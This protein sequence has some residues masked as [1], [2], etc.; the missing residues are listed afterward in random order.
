MLFKTLWIFFGIVLLS[1]LLGGINQASMSKLGRYA[2]L[3]LIIPTIALFLRAKPSE[4]WLWYGMAAGAVSSGLYA[5]YES[6]QMGIFSGNLY[7][8]HGMTGPMEFGHLAMVMGFI[9]VVGWSFFAKQQRWQIVIPLI[10]LLCGITGA[11]MSGTVGTLATLPALL[12]FS[13]WLASRRHDLRKKY[14]FS[15]LLAL[16]MTI[17]AA[18]WLFPQS[19]TA[20]RT[21]AAQN[22]IISYLQ[23][24][25]IKAD[26][27]MGTRIIMIEAAWEIFLKHPF[28]GAGEGSYKKE[29]TALALSDQRFKPIIRF[30]NPEN[31]FLHALISRGMPGLIS[32]LFLFLVP[33]RIFQRAA[34]ADSLRLSR[35]GGAG[36][37]V[38]LSYF[39]FCLTKS[40]LN[41]S[42]PLNFFIFALSVIVYQ[43]SSQTVDA[44]PNRSTAHSQTSILADHRSIPDSDSK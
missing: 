17:I 8:A 26:N 40:A 3:L 33:A 27:S 15:I 13:F 24:K 36:L 30:E 41:V 19:T 23:G 18:A 20:F 1:V 21:K 35:L 11:L 4:Q 22:V 12:L 32:L 37:T 14:Q 28:M 29:V 6:W 9:P 16:A 31:E 44:I 25:E 43:I 39:I 7:R 2:R 42:V 10:S 38:I 5:L 34:I